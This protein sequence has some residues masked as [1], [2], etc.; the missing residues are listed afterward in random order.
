MHNQCTCIILGLMSFLSQGSVLQIKDLLESPTEV[1]VVVVLF[2]PSVEFCA[3]IISSFFFYVVIPNL[4]L[5]SV[6]PG[7]HGCVQSVSR[8]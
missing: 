4:C 8:V 7:R 1:G 2:V 3:D 5:I 6:G